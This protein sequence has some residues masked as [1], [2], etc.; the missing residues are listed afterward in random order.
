MVDVDP[1]R[2]AD[3]LSAAPAHQV[4]VPGPAPR[5]LNPKTATKAPGRRPT[6]G[7]L[8]TFPEPPSRRHRTDTTAD[9]PGPSILE[10]AEPPGDLAG[11]EIGWHAVAPPLPPFG[12]TTPGSG[13]LLGADH[14]SQ[15][16]AVRLFRLQPTRIALIGGD[17]AARLIG[18]RAMGSGAQLLLPSSTEEE[19]STVFRLFQNGAGTPLPPSARRP[20]LAIHDDDQE[21]RTVTKVPWRTDL[22]VL[23][24]LEDIAAIGSRPYDLVICQRATEQEVAAMTP[25]LHLTE[26]TGYLLTAMEDSM[27]ALLGGGAN[28]YLWTMPTATELELLGP[29]RR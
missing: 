1:F 9:R 12:A 23:S 22:D 21:S 28:R 15:P 13:L 18:F 3:D 24:D 25:A 11:I 16:V 6:T 20:H 8:F 4:P 27:L 7:P 10:S 29:A 5:P 19:W 2:P 26:E 17:W 14:D